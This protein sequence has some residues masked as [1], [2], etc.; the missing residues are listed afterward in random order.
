MDCFGFCLSGGF[1]TSWVEVGA[2]IDQKGWCGR[3]GR[4]GTDH[5]AQLRGEGIK[6]LVAREILIAQM[7]RVKAAE[8]LGTWMMRRTATQLS[9]IGTARGSAVEAGRGEIE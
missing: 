3:D 2:W 7:L 8:G 1:E 9:T 5:W 4:S 6:A